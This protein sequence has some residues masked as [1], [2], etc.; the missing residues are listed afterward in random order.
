MED[1]VSFFKKIK[2][3]LGMGTIDFDLEVPPAVA[4]S[5]GRIDGTIVITAKTAQSIKDVEVKLDREQVWDQIEQRYNSTSNLYE[6][7]WVT[8]S[9]VDTIAQ[10]KDET[11]FDLAEGEVRRIPFALVFPVVEHPYGTADNLSLWD[12]LPASWNLGSGFRNMRISYRIDGDADVDGA[13]FDKG[14]STPI[15]LT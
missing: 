6:D 9:R 11:P 4:N 2:Q 13:A 8:K 1:I 3:S 12:F 14:E 5:S 15:T 7:Q 10:W